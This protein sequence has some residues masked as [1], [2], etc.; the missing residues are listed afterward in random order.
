MKWIVLLVL[1]GGC[2]P[3]CV[4][5]ERACKDTVRDFYGSDVSCNADQRLEILAVTPGKATVLCRCVD[6][7][8][9]R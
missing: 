9:F 2:D 8:A 5:R 1:L 7:G 3:G 6:A 4:P